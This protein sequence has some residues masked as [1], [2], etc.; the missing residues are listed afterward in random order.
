LI[1]GDR[2]ESVTAVMFE[3]ALARRG[4]AAVWRRTED[5]AE[6]IL[7]GDGNSLL[8]HVEHDPAGLNV[9]ISECTLPMT[10]DLRQWP[11]FGFMGDSNVST[12]NTIVTHVL[13]RAGISFPNPPTA[14][15]L[16][17]NKWDSHCIFRDAGLPVPKAALV[18]TVDEAQ[19]AAHRLGFPLVVKEL[20]GTQ[21]LGVRLARDETE[22]VAEIR[23]LHIDLQP[24]MLE[25]YIECGSMDRRVV[26][27]GNKLVA[28]MDRHAREGDFRANISLGGHG[29]KCVVSD[30]EVRLVERAQQLLGL[31]FVGM[32]IGIVA[33]VLPGREYLPVGSAFLIEANAEAGL[34]GLYRTTGVDGSEVVADMMLDDFDT[35]LTQVV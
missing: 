2:N 21:G 7:D 19:D 31:R 20:K 16:A 9:R 30:Y 18:T 24:L 8:S 32:D 3:S 11:L 27:V 6:Q 15:E 5:V 33:D 12:Y 10:S 4:V 23:D 35:P 25:H 28:A 17:Y 22:L 14:V 29:E 26:M 13:T 1:I 34:D